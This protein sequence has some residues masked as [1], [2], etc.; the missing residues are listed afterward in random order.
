MYLVPKLQQFHL[1]SQSIIKHTP[2]A[3]GTF[4]NAFLRLFLYT[5]IAKQKMLL[6]LMLLH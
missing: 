3:D 5:F 1:D 6:K 4:A 2:Y